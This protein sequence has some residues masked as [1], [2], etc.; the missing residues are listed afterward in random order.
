MGSKF[1][2]VCDPF[3]TEKARSTT[4]FA[5]HGSTGSKRVKWCPVSFEGKNRRER[6]K[7]AL[8]SHLFHVGS[9]VCL[10]VCLAL[11]YSGFPKTTKH[12]ASWWAPGRASPPSGASGS[13]GCLTFNTKVR[14]NNLK[15][16]YHRQTPESHRPIGTNKR[17]RQMSSSL[18]S[19]GRM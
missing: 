17:D 12:L 15:Q 11:P 1:T 10:F 16:W 14:G 4:A 2:L 7:L 3:Q 18:Q 5:R 6:N 13:R 8:A 19:M 9:F